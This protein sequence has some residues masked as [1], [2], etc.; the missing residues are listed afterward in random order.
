M[1]SLP[2]NR[3]EEKIDQLLTSSV[4]PGSEPEGLRIGLMPRRPEFQWMQ[5]FYALAGVGLFGF[6]LIQWLFIQNIEEVDFIHLFSWEVISVHLYGISS[7][8]VATIIG[9]AAAALLILPEKLK[10]LYRMF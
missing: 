1:N 4:S 2:E 6:F 9:L 5:L 10:L 7:G 8:T 3:L